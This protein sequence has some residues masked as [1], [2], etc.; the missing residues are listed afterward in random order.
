[1]M[2]LQ[3]TRRIFMK[4]KGNISIWHKRSNIISTQVIN[5][6]LFHSHFSDYLLKELSAHHWLRQLF[7]AFPQ[8]KVK[9]RPSSEQRIQNRRTTEKQSSALY[10]SLQAKGASCCR[11]ALICT[12]LTT[13]TQPTPLQLSIGSDQ[14]FAEDQ[15]ACWADKSRKETWWEFW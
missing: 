12:C 15:S 5:K 13:A 2:S 14:W 7:C 3:Q 1:M 8:L 9:G 10:V 11:E 6:T 4:E